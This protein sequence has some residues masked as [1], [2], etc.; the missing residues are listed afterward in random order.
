MDHV[1]VGGYLC[2]YLQMSII[3]SHKYRKLTTRFALERQSLP[4]LRGMSVSSF[5]LPRLSHKSFREVGKKR[6]TDLSGF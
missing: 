1:L 5:V 2:G 3:K 4:S 6:E